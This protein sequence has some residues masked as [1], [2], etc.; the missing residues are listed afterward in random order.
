MTLTTINLAALGDTINLTTEVT[1][2][3]PTANGGTNSTATTFVN[4]ASNVTGTLPTANGGTG[5]TSYSPGKV[6]QVIEDAST[7]ATTFTDTTYVDVGL[8]VTITP[9][10]T[11]SKILILANCNGFACNSTS[12][13]NGKIRLQWDQAGG[14]Y[15]NL[16]EYQQCN[17]YA[18]NEINNISPMYLHSPNTTSASIYK[19][20]GAQLSGFGD[21]SMRMNNR[22][23]DGGY[24][25]SSIVVME[26]AG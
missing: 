11:S 9:S 8:Q 18:D 26:I 6:L 15:D 3:L 7:T 1:G 24:C 22:Q 20:Q 16:H 2:T 5:G 12:G 19:I 13:G 10:A 14:S 21:G 25:R 17:G 4:A 23:A